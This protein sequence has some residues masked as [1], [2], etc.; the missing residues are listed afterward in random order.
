VGHD[1]WTEKCNLDFFVHHLLGN[2]FDIM[3]MQGS[4]E[5]KKSATLTPGSEE[6]LN[7]WNILQRIKYLHTSFI[8]TGA[9]QAL[10]L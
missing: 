4:H 9:L 10:E 3:T 2:L 8:K 1:I 5:A 7:V 6:H